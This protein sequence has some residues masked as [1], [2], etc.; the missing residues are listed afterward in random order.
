[1]AM[2]LTHMRVHIDISSIVEAVLSV[3]YSRAVMSWKLCDQ[4]QLDVAI[5]FKDQKLSLISECTFVNGSAGEWEG[6]RVVWSSRAVPVCVYAV[7]LK[8]AGSEGAFSSPCSSDGVVES[9]TG[10]TQPL[11]VVMRRGFQV[12]FPREWNP[13]G[14]ADTHRVS[15]CVS[16][17]IRFVCQSG[18][19]THKR[20][21]GDCPIFFAWWAMQCFD[22]YFSCSA[23]GCGE[24]S[25][26]DSENGSCCLGASV[27]HHTTRATHIYR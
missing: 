19:L 3:W 15:M 20:G 25:V 24:M 14:V 8:G 4:V 13:P 27:A 12:P 16:E 9:A 6:R 11:S 5:M 23:L 1:M 21:V 17:E 2:F 10:V 22:H 26:H 18:G 7:G